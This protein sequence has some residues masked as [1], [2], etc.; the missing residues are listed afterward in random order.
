MEAV[1][2]H[3]ITSERLETIAALENAVENNKLEEFIQNDSFEH[4]WLLDPSWERADAVH[5]RSPKNLSLRLSHPQEERGFID[6]QYRRMSGAYVIV[7]LK[8][9]GVS[10]YPR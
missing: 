7:E 2:Y 10:R 1:H 9:P 4:L 3:S 6:I 5:P 8:R